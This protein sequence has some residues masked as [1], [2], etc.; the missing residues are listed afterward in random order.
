MTERPYTVIITKC[1]KNCNTEF[2]RGRKAQKNMTKL[3]V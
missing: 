2:L 1:E 3:A